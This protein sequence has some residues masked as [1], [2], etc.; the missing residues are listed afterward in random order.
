MINIGIVIKSTGSWYSVKSNSQIFNCK[1]KGKFRIKGFK[2]TNPVAVGDIVDFEIVDS[3]DNTGV[4]IKIHERKNYIIRK[5]TNLSHQANIIAAN[6]DYAFIVATVANPKTYTEFID[7]FLVTCEVNNITGI[8]ILNKIDTYSDEQNVYLQNITNI[9]EKAGY[10]CIHIS[11]KQNINIDAVSEIIADKTIVISGNSGVGKSSLI[12]LLQPGLNL[13][14]GE[15][16][17]YSQKGKH[18][19]TFAEMFDIANGRI[20]DTPGVKGFG[21]VDVPAE[22][23]SKYFPEMNKIRQNCRYNNCT[24]T[25]E[26]ACAVK[27]AVE[28]GEISKERYKNYL[29][30]LEDTG[31]KYRTDDYK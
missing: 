7:R 12:N 30:I 31:A 24:H 18:T 21:L 11:V 6:I 20:I 28:S 10:K 23:L 9:Y 4:I 15:I 22:T 3:N 27:P 19:T 2:S 29:S 26:P 17:D 14:T 1:I 25:H 13:K 16:S 8:I 5:S